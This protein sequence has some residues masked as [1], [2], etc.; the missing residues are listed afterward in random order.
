M[1]TWLK[2]NDR[3]KSKE[4]TVRTPPLPKEPE[5]A[6]KEISEE[7]HLF[8]PRFFIFLCYV[9]FYVYSCS[10]FCFYVCVFILFMLLFT[11]D[12]LPNLKWKKESKQPK[13]N[14]ISS[15]E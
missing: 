10:C 1:R 12:G 13:K 6:K 8:R 15:V 2:Q 14:K 11:L 4:A 5:K 3:I 9:C 7:Q